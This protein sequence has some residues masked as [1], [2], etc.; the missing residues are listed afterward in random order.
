MAW[1]LSVAFGNHFSN[2][3]TENRLPFPIQTPLLTMA[4]KYPIVRF[5]YLYRDAGNYKKWGFIDFKNMN[6][7]ELD[8]I[9]SRLKKSF[10]MGCLFNA[11]QAKV[12]E[13]FIFF[14]EEYPVNADDVGWHEYDSVEIVDASREDINLYFRSIGWFVK[15]VEWCQQVGWIAYDP[16]EHW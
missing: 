8:E 6:G 4:R 2:P 15:H 9:H 5:N 12:P 7:L 14:D 3:Y 13:V 1:A 11:K 16:R 10:D